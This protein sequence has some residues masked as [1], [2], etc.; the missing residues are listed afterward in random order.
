MQVYHCLVT[1]R[2]GE[3]PTLRDL[4]CETRDEVE[5]AVRRTIQEWSGVHQV[6][7]FLN[8]EAIALFQADEAGNLTA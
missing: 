5:R 3:V 7:V 2:P 6:E 4:D 1:T 8:G